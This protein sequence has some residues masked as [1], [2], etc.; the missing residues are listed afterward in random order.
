MSEALDRDWE[1]INAYADDELPAE[2][3]E[4]LERR[5]AEEPALQDMLGE[6]QGLSAALAA[7]KPQSADVRMPAAAAAV[8]PV[9][10]PAN[11]R[12]A[13]LI[14]AASVALA[15][16]A[17]GALLTAALQPPSSA[18]GWHQAFLDE[19]YGPVEG[20]LPAASALRY[21]DS[22]GAPDLRLASL[23]LV[24]RRKTARGSYA[25]HYSGRNGCRLTVLSTEGAAPAAPPDENAFHE[26]WTA[27][28]RSFAV[29][30]TGMDKRRFNAVAAFIREVTRSAAQQ[31]DLL[32]MKTSAE[33]AA[34]CQ[35]A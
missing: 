30:A 12:R 8:A 17:G 29:I 22:T 24:D 20:P 9:P 19:D 35:Q 2:D 14:R 11:R 4:A 31:Q 28:G 26:S 18:I 23:F 16:M 13:P 25:S 3:R 33:T 6:V 21:S 27:G 34:P 15:L 32:A 7:L 1:L 10:V 5:L